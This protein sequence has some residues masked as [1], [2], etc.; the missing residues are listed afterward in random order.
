MSL[1]DYDEAA[2]VVRCDGRELN[3][4]DPEA[5]ELISQAPGGLGYEIRVWVLLAGEAQIQLPKT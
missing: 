2:G 3:L 1:G 4:A 5:F